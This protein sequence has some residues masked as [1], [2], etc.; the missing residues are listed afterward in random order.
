MTAQRS[1]RVVHLDPDGFAD[2]DVEREL[3]EREL[4]EVVFDEVDASGTA[5]GE[6]V[7][8]AD[9][10]LTHY[11]SVPVEALDATNCSVVARYATGVDGI[12]VNAATERGVAVT[13][14]PRYCDEEVG[15]HVTALALALLRSL[16]QADAQTASGIGTGERYSDPAPSKDSRSDVSP[17]DGRQQRQPTEPQLSDLMWWPMTR[18]STTQ[19]YGAEGLNPSHSTISSAEAMSSHCTRR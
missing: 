7:G 6:C 5:I 17:L 10:L 15:E 18:M 14:V 3:F 8:E 16:P 12:D 13:N 19:I 4:G 9:V 2:L 1:V 11:A